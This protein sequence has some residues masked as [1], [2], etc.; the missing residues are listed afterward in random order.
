MQLT[1]VL[2]SHDINVV[3]A[4]ANRLFVLDLKIFRH[5]LCEDPG[6]QLF[7]RLY[8]HD[9]MAHIHFGGRCMINKVCEEESQK[10]S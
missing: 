2:V 5:D 6:R 4:R 7:R 9:I 3:T 1:I 10:K 8:G